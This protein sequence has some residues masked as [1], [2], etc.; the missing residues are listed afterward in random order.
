M[1]FI[2]LTGCK[3]TKVDYAEPVS[4]TP[5]TTDFSFSDVNF[6]ANDMVDSMLISPATV[7]IT[8]DR[9]P[10]V[11][12]DRIRNKTD[13]HIDTESITDTI[14]TQL[15]RSGKF[16]FTDKVTRADQKEELEYQ[17]YSGMV[18]PNNK[19]DIGKQYGAEYMV[20]GSIVSYVERNSKVLR[21]SYKFNL[22]LTNIQTGVIEWSD[23]VP[24]TKQQTRSTFG[25]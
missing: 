22:I 17:N 2:G 11:V 21:K 20:T 16:R 12:V 6:V 3:T 5:L 15:I 4:A 19:A 23:E 25:R 14:R 9:R 8:Q 10:L 13:Q 24:I 18:D 1:V 7:A